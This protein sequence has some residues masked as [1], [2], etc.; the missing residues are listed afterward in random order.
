VTRANLKAV[1]RGLDPRIHAVADIASVRC[2]DVDG[3]I[4]SGHDNS[5]FHEDYCACGSPLLAN[6]AGHA[7]KAQG[8]SGRAA[9]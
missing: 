1:M 5:A 4:K 2:K 6:F 3:R 8:N 9:S 7:R